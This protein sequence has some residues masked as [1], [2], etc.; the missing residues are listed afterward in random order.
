MARSVWPCWCS[1]AQDSQSMEGCCKFVFAHCAAMS[2][3]KHLRRI[4]SA[5][6]TY[7]ATLLAASTPAARLHLR[8]MMQLHR[9]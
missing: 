9:W 2:A 7:M 5:L 3:N 4:A 1:V 8:L 6:R